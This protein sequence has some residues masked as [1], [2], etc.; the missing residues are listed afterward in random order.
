MKK[1]L[2]AALGL[3]AMTATADAA[4]SGFWVI[5]GSY[6]QNLEQEAMDNSVRVIRAA[7][8][9]GYK[10]SVGS[11]DRMIG[12]KDGLIIQVIG[13][14]GSRGEAEMIRDDV[15]RCVRDAFVKQGTYV[16]RPKPMQFN[17]LE[18]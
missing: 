13:P 16:P 4:M 12:L 15:R 5:V 10:P 18:D 8:R 1:T 3:L 7:N 6:P 2:L 14:F 9:C 17:G 11:S